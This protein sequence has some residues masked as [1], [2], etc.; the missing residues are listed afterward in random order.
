MTSGDDTTD[1][2]SEMDTETAESEAVLLHRAT[3]AATA[4]MDDLMTTVDDLWART[5]SGSARM[6]QEEALCTLPFDVLTTLFYVVEHYC[7]RLQT[8]GVAK[9]RVVRD[10]ESTQNNLQSDE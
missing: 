3:T 5:P 7:K 1:S 10:W 6:S 4:S 8:W 2:Q 9:E